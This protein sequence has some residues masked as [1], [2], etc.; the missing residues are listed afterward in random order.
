ML[1][2]GIFVHAT[3]LQ[4]CHRAIEINDDRQ[5]QHLQPENPLSKK[6]AHRS[7]FVPDAN[8][9]F[10]LGMVKGKMKG[11]R[12]DDFDLQVIFLCIFKCHLSEI[13]CNSP[14]AQRLRDFSVKK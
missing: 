6:R 4:A 2:R 5:P 9:R 7:L 13:F 11:Y 8:E 10:V 12:T 1:R 14:T 3:R